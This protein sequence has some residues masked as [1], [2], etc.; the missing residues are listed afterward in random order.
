MPTVDSIAQGG[1]SAGD[2]VPFATFENEVD[3][4]GGVAR[5]RRGSADTTGSSASSCT[6]HAETRLRCDCDDCEACRVRKGLLARNGLCMSN[7]VVGRRE[8]V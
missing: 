8:T 7:A 3:V 5:E 6:R 2:S 4:Q 1:N